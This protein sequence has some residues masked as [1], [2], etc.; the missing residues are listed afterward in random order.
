MEAALYT[1]FIVAAACFFALG[2]KLK[3]ATNFVLSFSCL[4]FVG[5]IF[6]FSRFPEVH[7]KTPVLDIERKVTKVESDQEEMRRVVSLLIRMNAVVEDGVG[8]FA[9]TLDKRNQVLKR[10]QEELAP[11][12]TPED[13]TK[14]IRDINSIYEP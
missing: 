13:S 4:V 10:Y 5:G 1:L 8:K 14:L 12:L 2:V 3:L 7:L 9:D 6:L 11:Y